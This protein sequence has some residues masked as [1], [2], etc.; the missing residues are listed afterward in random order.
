MS[1]AR[2]RAGWTATRDQ[3]MA[4]VKAHRAAIK[5]TLAQQVEELTLEVLAALTH[6]EWAA[7]CDAAKRHTSG[8]LSDVA[9]RNLSAAVMAPAICEIEQYGRLRIGQ[10]E[11]ASNFL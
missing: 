1:R 8:Q 2:G 7:L 6:A 5:P 9:W 10:T 11:Q 3:A 4:D